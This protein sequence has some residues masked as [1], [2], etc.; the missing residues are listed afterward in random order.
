VHRLSNGT[1]L[2]VGVVTTSATVGKNLTNSSSELVDFSSLFSKTPVVLSQIQTVATDGAPNLQT[3]HL[4]VS[5]SS[6]S[7]A[8]EQEEANTEPHVAETVGYMAIEAGNGI[9]S[10]MVYETATISNVVTH[11]WYDLAFDNVYADEPTFLTSLATYYGRDN[12]HLSYGNLTTS[13][14]QIKI[15][16]DTTTD[17]EIDHHVAESVAYLAIGGTGILTGRPQFPPQVAAFLRD[18]GGDTYDLLGTIQYTFNE[19]VTVTA[20]A[21]QLANATDIS[22]PIDLASIGFSYDANSRTATWDFSSLSRLEAAWYTVRL[23]AAQISDTSGLMLDGNEDGTAGDPYTH[24]LLVAQRGDSDL[25]GDVDV[26]DFNTLKQYFDPLG[27]GGM[28][29]WS[30]AD[31]DGD[32]DIDATD[33]YALVKV[34]SHSVM[35]RCPRPRPIA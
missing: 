11:A 3:R 9:W 17:T 21:L 16:E 34:F 29:D 4:S 15:T 33:I 14:A 26:T 24:T 28:N 30:R 20:N 19:D 31:F 6:A 2:E 27:L 13:S 8:L 1:R 10:G 35:P 7:L 18:G 5:S 32:G 23:D 25:D 22:N 12:A